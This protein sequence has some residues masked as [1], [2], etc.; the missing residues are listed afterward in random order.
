LEC[1]ILTLKHF[2][3]KN[4]SIRGG[5]VELAEVDPRAD[6]CCPVH[7]KIREPDLQVVSTNELTLTKDLNKI[8]NFVN[9]ENKKTENRYA[10]TALL[11]ALNDHA[12]RIRQAIEE[13]RDVYNTV[14]QVCLNSKNGIVQPQVLSPG[15]L[16]EILKISQDSFPRDLKVPV[17]LSEAYAFVLYDIVSVD[18]Y[19][20]GNNLEY[21][22]KVPLVMHSVFNVFKVTPFPMQVKGMGGIFTLIQPEK[23]FIVNDNIKRFYAKLE[24]TYCHIRL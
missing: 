19:L 2:T 13:V 22:V 14:I 5:A 21:T 6:Y 3:I 15:R 17:V 11:L 20:V 9:V 23:K 12:T 16:I 1:W 10:L 24:Q 7:S 18:V 8:L 4:F